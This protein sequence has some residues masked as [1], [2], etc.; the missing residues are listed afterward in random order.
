M[1]FYVPLSHLLSSGLMVAITN[2]TAVPVTGNPG[3]A[4][5]TIFIARRCSWPCYW[6]MFLTIIALFL[7]RFTSQIMLLCAAFDSTCLFWYFSVCSSRL[8]DVTTIFQG[9]KAVPQT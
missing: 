5:F 8:S 1:V 7:V 6:H 3:G 9:N 4:N 2:S